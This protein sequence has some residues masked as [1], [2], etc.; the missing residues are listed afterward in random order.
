MTC[1]T[2]RKI[3]RVIGKARPKRVDRSGTIF[4][5]GLTMPERIMHVTA[6][7]IVAGF[8]FWLAWTGLVTSAAGLTW[9]ADTLI[10]VLGE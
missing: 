2:C 1:R 9:I 7:L 10:S 5:S 3:R 8:G 6:A 4:R